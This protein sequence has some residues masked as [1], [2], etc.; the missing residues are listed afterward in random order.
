MKLPKIIF[1]ISTE[2]AYKRAM[3]REGNGE[4]KKETSIQLSVQASINR[5]DYVKVPNTNTLI[6]K[7]EPD[8]SKGLTWEKTHYKLAENGLFMPA[9]ALFMPYFMNVIDAYNGKIQLYD[10]LGN[11]I[12]RKEVEDI[13]KH[14]TINHVNNGAYSWLDA[15]FKEENNFWYIETEHRVING[16][17]KGTRQ[18]LEICLMEDCYVSLDFNKQGLAIKKSNNQEYEQGKNIKFVYPKDGTVAGFVANSDWADLDCYRIPQDSS[19]DLGVF[20]CAEGT[21][22]N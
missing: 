22:K 14:L 1:G 8:E 11:Q 9:P 17:L 20:P 16:K 13:Y 6:A 19:S 12:N 2:E 15:L 3:S 7:F 5:K 21:S 18:P 10:G 4:K